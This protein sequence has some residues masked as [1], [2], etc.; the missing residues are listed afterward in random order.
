VGQLSP[1]QKTFAWVIVACLAFLVGRA[2]N[3]PPQGGAAQSKVRDG[4][5][6]AALR[7]PG[8]VQ[9]TAPVVDT[10]YVTRTGTKY[11]TAGYGY[12][13]QSSIPIVRE[14]AIRRGYTPCSRCYR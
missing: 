9:Q 1:R 13:R 12:L 5:P 10:V 2:W 6:A 3:G 11:H 14:D 8:P 4:I 7:G